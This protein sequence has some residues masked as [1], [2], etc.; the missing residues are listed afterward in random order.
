MREH[1]SETVSTALDGFTIELPSWGFAD[2][3]T[4]FGKFLQPAAAV[5][6]EE[7]LEALLSTPQAPKKKKTGKRRKS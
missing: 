1:L 5:T 2:T 7:K 6:L 4:R 3:G